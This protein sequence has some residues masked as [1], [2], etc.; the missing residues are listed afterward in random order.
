MDD[1][2]MDCASAGEPRT[3]PAP[4]RAIGETVR[5]FRRSRRWSIEQLAARAEVSYQYLCEIENGKRNFSIMVLDR[6]ARAL[7]TTLLAV[8][9]AALA[10][11]PA[12]RTAA[13]DPLSEAA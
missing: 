7:E 2:M 4:T 11:R 3:G 9:G 10:P 6:I 12:T 8:V 13:E 1:A 5:Q